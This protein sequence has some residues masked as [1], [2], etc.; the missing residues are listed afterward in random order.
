MK[1]GESPS[2]PPK[3]LLYGPAGGGKTALA[4]TLGADAQILDLDD[5]IMTGITL[6]DKY[7]EERKK[8]ELKQ[9]LEPEI[10][11]K[12]LAYN[13]F[14]TY[15]FGLQGEIAK[16]KFPYKAL[17]IDSLTSLGEAC[18]KFV[19]GNSGSIMS[20]PEI[21]HWGLI[22]NEMQNV[23]GVIKSLPIVVVLLAHDEEKTTGS[24]VG[25]LNPATGKRNPSTAKEVTSIAVP[26]RKLIA[27]I[28]RFYDEIWYTRTRS[29][30]GK[31]LEYYLQTRKTGDLIARSRLNLPDDF[32]FARVDGDKSE[33]AVGL[34]EIIVKLGYRRPQNVEQLS[35][36]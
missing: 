25:E 28:P 32:V 10:A 29:K 34:W 5:G 31:K 6:Q 11:T 12:A 23:M 20:A 27:R 8:V 2:K 33:F 15:I 18:S 4:L 30:G 36:V 19:M 24:L 3:I 26:T 22:V 16:G 7:T 1:V 13:Q 35:S 17:I 9:F 21:Q 14:K